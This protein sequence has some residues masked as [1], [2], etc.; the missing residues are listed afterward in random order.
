VPLPLRVVAVLCDLLLTGVFAGMTYLTVRAAPRTAAQAHE[1]WA[2]LSRRSTGYDVVE[3]SRVLSYGV[4]LVQAAMTVGVFV[5]FTL[6]AAGR[7]A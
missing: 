1:R 7:I 4:A 2:R 3:A 6:I 5:V